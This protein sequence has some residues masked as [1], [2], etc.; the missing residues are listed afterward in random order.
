MTW[1]LPKTPSFANMRSTLIRSLQAS[2][3]ISPMW[4]AASHQGSAG[5][6]DLW[7]FVIGSFDT[8]VQKG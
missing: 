5:C 1:S 2:L 3:D 8:A 6:G 7:L 4:C